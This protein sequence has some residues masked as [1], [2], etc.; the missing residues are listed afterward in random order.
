MLSILVLMVDIT[1]IIIKAI[2]ETLLNFLRIILNPAVPEKQNNMALNA[3][4]F[5][6]MLLVCLFLHQ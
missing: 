3:L 2:I 4:P 1:I 5:Q 6:Q